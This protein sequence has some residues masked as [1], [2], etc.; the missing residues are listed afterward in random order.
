[1]DEVKKLSNDEIIRLA[2]GSL[3]DNGPSAERA[4][5]EIRAL[6]QSD[7]TRVLFVG[8]LLAGKS[9]I[10]ESDERQNPIVKDYRLLADQVGG[11]YEICDGDDGLIRWVFKPAPRS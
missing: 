6:N 1:M 8:E 7:K 3:S 5:A 9:F 4:A 2:M 11:I 10:I